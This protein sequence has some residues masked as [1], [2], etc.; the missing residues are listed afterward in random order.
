MKI[1]ELNIVE[2]GCLRNKKIV[3]GDGL[4]VIHGENESG[5]STIML[6]IRFMFYGLPARSKKNYDRERSLSFEGD[7]KSVV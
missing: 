2:F 4:N 5:K 7:Q 1:K 6:F 3:L